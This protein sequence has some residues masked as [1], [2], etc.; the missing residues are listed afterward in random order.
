MAA[1][2]RRVIFYDQLGCGNSEQVHDPSLWTVDLFVEEVGVVRNALDLGRCHLLGF[3]WGGALAMEYALTK[4]GGLVSL[5]LASSIASLPQFLS[6]TNRLRSDLPPSVQETFSHHEEAGTMDAPAYQAA[7]MVFI[8]KH[9]C[10]LDPFPEYFIRML[11]KSAQNP[12]VSNTMWGGNVFFATGTLK[13]WNI[14]D[15][16]GEIYVPTLITSGRN[17]VATPVV[18]ET[19]HQGIPNSEWVLFEHS[20][21][22]SHA[23]EPEKYAQMLDQF[24][25]RVEENP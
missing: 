8:R 22:L 2:G 4:P 14:M 12:E 7:M 1:T 13:E 5:I 21:H 6:E 17:D 15:R 11:E 25:S 23:E 10:R 20:S 16:L 19:L 24:L 9:F 3:S 18:S